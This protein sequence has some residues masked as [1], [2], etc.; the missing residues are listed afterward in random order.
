MLTPHYIYTR[1]NDVMEEY[2]RHGICEDVPENDSAAES[3]EV[4]KYYLPHH[5]VLCEEKAT[6]KLRV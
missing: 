5:A 6:T 2:L 4:V 3:A 1:Y